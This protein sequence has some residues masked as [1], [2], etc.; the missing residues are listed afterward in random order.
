M[1]NTIN[2]EFC[3]NCKNFEG[4]FY[5][6]IFLNCAIKP[7]GLDADTCEDFEQIQNIN[8]EPMFVL[9]ELEL[10]ERRIRTIENNFMSLGRKPGKIVVIDINSKYL[11]KTD[12]NYFQ[13]LKQFLS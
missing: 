7:F 6:G 2:L 9:D 5:N 11:K 10:F 1:P 8:R 12:E 13:K 3:R 4:Q